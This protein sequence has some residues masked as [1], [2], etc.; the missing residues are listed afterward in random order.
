M[1]L[2]QVLLIWQMM[3]ETLHFMKQFYNL[4][5]LNMKKNIIVS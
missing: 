1:L 3:L 5:V 2:K 4:L